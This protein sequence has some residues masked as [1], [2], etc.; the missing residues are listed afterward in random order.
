MEIEIKSLK[1][2]YFEAISANRI[3]KKSQQKNNWKRF[4]TITGMLLLLTSSPII[5]IG[6]FI[7]EQRIEIARVLNA[8]LFHLLP[9]Y[10][11]LGL[12]IW[13][14]GLLLGFVIFTIKHPQISG[15]T[16]VFKEDGIQIS[17]DQIITHSDWQSYLGYLENKKFFILVIDKKSYFAIPKRLL[18]LEKQESFRNLVKKHITDLMT[19]NQ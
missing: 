2:S 13:I 5:V 16:L 3:I 8:L 10:L 9:A 14:I 12:I 1:L 19:F 7:P 11:L 4:L 18:P 17:T 15:Y 6:I